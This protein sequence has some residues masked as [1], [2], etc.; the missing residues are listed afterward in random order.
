MTWFTGILRRSLQLFVVLY[1]GLYQLWYAQVRNE[2][3]FSKN[4][5]YFSVL[6]GLPGIQQCWVEYN[7]KGRRKGFIQ[8]VFLNTLQ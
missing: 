7:Y 3:I 4:N 6:S 1:V 8:N 5:F 2:N